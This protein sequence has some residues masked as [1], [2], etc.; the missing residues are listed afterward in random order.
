M[1]LARSRGTIYDRDFKGCTV[2]ET[3]ISNLISARLIHTCLSVSS[4][5]KSQKKKKKQ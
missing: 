5:G 4:Q 2:N 1:E 3:C